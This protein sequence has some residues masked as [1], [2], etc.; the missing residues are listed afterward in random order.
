MP[1]SPQWFTKVPLATRVS[2][3]I[4]PHYSIQWN[5]PWE[6]FKGKRQSVSL[7]KSLLPW[8]SEVLYTDPTQED[9]ETRML[10]GIYI[11]RES[12]VADRVLAYDPDK[13]TKAHWFETRLEKIW[14]G[15]NGHRRS[16]H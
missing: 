13:T 12:P 6:L 10:P 7:F 4:S 16:L 2:P 8:E 15:E 1:S 3:R 9:K 5:S 11:G 14:I